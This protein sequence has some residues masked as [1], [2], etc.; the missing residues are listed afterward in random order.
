MSCYRFASASATSGQYAWYAAS[1]GAAAASIVTDKTGNGNTGRVVSATGLAAGSDASGTYNLGMVAC[2]SSV[3]YVSGT[4]TT[5]LSFA[6]LPAGS[7]FSLC[8]VARYASGSANTNRIVGGTATG[9]GA[10]SYAFGHIGAT[11]G[12]AY[13]GGTDQ[14]YLTSTQQSELIPSDTDWLIQV[15][16]EP[17]SPRVSGCHT[18]GGCAIARYHKPSQSGF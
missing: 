12:S 6:T 1:A 17:P 3:P 16:V 14:S 2:A 9:V 7:V 18:I 5:Q 4:T 8:A 15:R 11:P 13:F 10:T